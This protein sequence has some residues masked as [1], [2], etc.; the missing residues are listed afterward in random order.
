MAG[1]APTT[2]FNSGYAYDTT[3]VLKPSGA[4]TASS[5][6]Q[7]TGGAAGTIVDLGAGFVEGNVIID[8]SAL[9]VTAGNA[10]VV[11]VTGTVS[12]STFGTDTNIVEL[13]ASPL[14]GDVAARLTDA[15]AADDT[16]GRY[17]VPFRNEKFGQLYR[18]IR[19]YTGIVSSG[20]ITYSAVLTVHDGK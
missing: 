5:S 14:M 3:L 7:A 9:T 17:V 10:A 12:D 16:T 2:R 4:I 20:A 1:A 19:I 18:Y 6:L 8:V 13:C 15:N 11:Y